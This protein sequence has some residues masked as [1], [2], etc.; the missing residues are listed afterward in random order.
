MGYAQSNML[1]RNMTRRLSGRCACVGGS[2]FSIPAAAYT[3]AQ[4]TDGAVSGQSAAE[5]PDCVRRSATLS[6]RKFQA[7]LARLVAA[8]IS[9]VRRW[10]HDRLVSSWRS[11]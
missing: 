6:F 3:R 7:E 10:S 9:L 4:V 8:S 5:M 1:T 2:N 11:E